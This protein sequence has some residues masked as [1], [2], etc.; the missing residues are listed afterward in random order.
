MSYSAASTGFKKLKEKFRINSTCLYSPRIGGPT[1]MFQSGVSDHIID[2]RGRWRDPK[3]KFIY[4]K[5]SEQFLINTICK[6]W[7]A[8]RWY[9]LFP[10]LNKCNINL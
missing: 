1:D 2:K 7:D 3:T 9:W 8:I 10:I 6:L 4:A 5:D